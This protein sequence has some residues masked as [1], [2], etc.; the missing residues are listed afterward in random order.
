[1]TSSSSVGGVSVTL[2]LCLNRSMDAAAR[3]VQA[4]INAARADLPTSLR[5]NPTY[6]KVDPADAPILILT[7]TSDTLTRGN[8]YDAASTVLSQKLSQVDGIGEVIVGGSSLPA[9]RAELIP[10]ALYKYG[11]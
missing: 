4:S 3:D 6:R 2:Q 1:M 9:V 5:T 7:L 10:Q 8:L 11:V